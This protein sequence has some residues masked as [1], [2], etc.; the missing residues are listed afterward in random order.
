MAHLG[1][2]TPE[3]EIG[4]PAEMSIEHEEKA[5]DKGEDPI[6]HIE[7]SV[8]QIIATASLAALWVGQ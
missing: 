2:T 3:K 7:W 5:S 8:R 1:D 4:S 6:E